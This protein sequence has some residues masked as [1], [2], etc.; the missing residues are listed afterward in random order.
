MECSIEGVALA[1]H[2]SKSPVEQLWEKGPSVSISNEL[3][4]TRNIHTHAQLYSLSI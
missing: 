1:K 2:E 4:V 3:N